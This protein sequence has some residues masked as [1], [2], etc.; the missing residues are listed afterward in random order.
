MRFVEKMFD[1]ESHKTILNP[2]N[3]SA[4][5]YHIYTFDTESEVVSSLNSSNANFTLK[6]ISRLQQHQFVKLGHK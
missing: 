2:Q 3:K 1:Y 4:P 6:C 5:E